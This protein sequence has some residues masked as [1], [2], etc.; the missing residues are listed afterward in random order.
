MDP[1]GGGRD[2]AGEHLRQGGLPGAVRPDQPDELPLLQ[3]KVEIPD[4]GLLLVFPLPE[5]PDAAGKPLRLFEPAVGLGKSFGLNDVH[6]DTLLALW[7]MLF[8]G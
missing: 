2:D 1:P 6:D 4:G 8:Y 5:A 3:S 7:R